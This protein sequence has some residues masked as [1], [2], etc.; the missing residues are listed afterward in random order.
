M[1]RSAVGLD[2]SGDFRIGVPWLRRDRAL[3]NDFWLG[4]VAL[5]RRRSA[6]RQG[7]VGRAIVATHRLVPRFET[8]Y[9]FP[10]RSHFA[11]EIAD[12][13]L[14]DVEAFVQR[15]VGSGT[16]RG[17]VDRPSQASP[18]LRWSRW[19][20][21]GRTRPKKRGPARTVSGFRMSEL[22]P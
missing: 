3:G 18:T 10:Q 6:S 7:V 4:D 12:G 8:V 21:D 13:P 20:Q 15:G 11:R 1:L 17:D 19:R 14:E 2:L 9:R 22:P 5:T 16:W